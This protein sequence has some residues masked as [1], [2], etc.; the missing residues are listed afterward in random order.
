MMDIG[1]WQAQLRAARG[2]PRRV[3]AGQSRLGAAPPTVLHVALGADHGGFALKE[4]LRAD[5]EA[6]GYAVV[7]CGTG[8]AAAVDYPDFAAAVG[9]EVA[10]GRCARGIVIDAAGL[11]SCIAANKVRGVRAA[12]CHDELTVRNSRLHNDTNVLALGARV[13][14]PGL[15]RR[16]ARLWLTT[17]FEGGRHQARIDK[18]SALEG[19]R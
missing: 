4:R 2:T 5:L 11:G 3:P 13:V 9:R 8:S 18:I 14:N 7:D 1:Q 12:A 19:E 16:L 17:P 10:S 15:G 6:W